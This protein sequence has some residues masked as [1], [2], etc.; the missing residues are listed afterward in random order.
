MYVNSQYYYYF[1]RNKYFLWHFLHSGRQNTHN[2]LL[3]NCL[4]GLYFSQKSVDLVIYHLLFHAGRYLPEFILLVSEARFISGLTDSLLYGGGS[5][6]V[7][8][9]G[10]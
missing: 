5:E 4:F 10:S 1:F 2:Q 7:R 6:A 8:C 9:A 3:A